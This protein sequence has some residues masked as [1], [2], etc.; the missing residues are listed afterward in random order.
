MCSPGERCKFRRLVEHG[1]AGE[2]GRHEDVAAD[3]V[4]IVPGRD[5]GDDAERLVVDALG[6][7]GVGEDGLRRRRRL[8]LV[9]EEVDPAEEAVQLV[10]RLRERLAD[11]ARQ[12]LGQRLQLGGDGGA[13][14]DDVRLALG[15][16]TR[17]PGRL[18]RRASVALRATLAASS[19]G[20]RRSANRRPGC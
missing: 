19:A 18:R 5:V 9:E 13:E 17:R 8:D 16:R 15:Q 11:L 10:A 3:E 4:R 14:A 20:S 12:R 2:Q 1:V 6:H 7:G